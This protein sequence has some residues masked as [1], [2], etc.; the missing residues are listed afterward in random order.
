MYTQLFYNNYNLTIIGIPIG[1]NLY[2][3]LHYTIGTN[4]MIDI[5]RYNPCFIKLNRY[6]RIIMYVKTCVS[7]IRGNNIFYNNILSSI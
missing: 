4:R 2:F 7:L 1:K 3:F 5:H 6:N